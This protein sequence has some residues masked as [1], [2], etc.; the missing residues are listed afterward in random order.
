MKKFFIR[1]LLLS[2][3]GLGVSAYLLFH[4]TE[5]KYGFQVEKSFCSISELFDCDTVA[6]SSYSEFLGIPLASYGFLY[7]AL[8]IYILR[9]RKE[10]VNKEESTAETA[11]LIFV[12]ALASLPVDLVL[13]YISKFLIGKICLMCALMYLINFMLILLAYLCKDRPK[14]LSETFSLGVKELF[15]YLI[16]A[17]K[18]SL[19]FL[20]TTAVFFTAIYY[21]PEKVLVKYYFLPEQIR[22]VSREALAPMLDLWT[23]NPVEN[24]QLNF[25]GDNATKD[26]FF[27]SPDAPLTIVEF[28][29][30]ECPFCKKASDF[31]RNYVKNNYNKVKIVYKGFPIDKACNPLIN[32]DKHLFACESAAM[33]RCA[34]IVSGDEYFWKMYDHLMALEEFNDQELQQLPKKIGINEESFRECMQGEE[35]EK[36]IKKDL[37]EGVALHVKYTPTLFFNGKRARC[38]NVRLLPGF[39]ELLLNE[40]IP[41]K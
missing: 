6:K 23:G 33:V 40:Y 3:I 20:A 29:D 36:R 34:G 18:K 32:V 22:S 38:D 31:L 15:T 7:F 19:S 11:S 1:F 37:D 26:Y 17:R 4:H 35:V 25:D 5:I 16:P 14:T 8:L 39:I 12:Y 30:F 28:V 27:G 2:F 21:L 13:I 10:L 9:Q 24:I 41:K